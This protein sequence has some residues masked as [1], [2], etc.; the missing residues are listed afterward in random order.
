M[1][2]IAIWLTGL[3][4]FLV[5]GACSNSS[6]IYRHTY[7]PSPWWGYRDYQDDHL[8]DS[9]EDIDSQQ[10]DLPPGKPPIG[11]PAEAYTEKNNNQLGRN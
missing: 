11:M 1:G 8:S 2:K 5:I 6:A 10:A 3:T 7:D 9:P 4:A